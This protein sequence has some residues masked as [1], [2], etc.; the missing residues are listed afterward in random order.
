VA[1]HEEEE[2]DQFN[3]PGWRRRLDVFLP[4]L[5]SSFLTREE[6]RQLHKL[7]FVSQHDLSS[8]SKGM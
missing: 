4:H 7:G 5:A 3:V 8:P 1:I 2:D 6:S